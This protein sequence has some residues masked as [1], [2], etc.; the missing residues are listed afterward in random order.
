MT[1]ERSPN[2]VSDDELLRRLSRSVCDS[3]RVEADVV[4]DIGEVDARRLFAREASPSMYSYCTQVLHLSEAEAYL[5]IN[6]ARA[7]RRH[8]ILLT[9]LRDGRLHLT[10]IVKLA[11]HLTEANRDV[12]LARAT[13][14]SKQQVEELLAELF[15]RPDVPVA[16]RKLPQKAAAVEAR[17]SPSAVP[18]ETSLLR[19]D[20]VV[21]APAPPTAPAVVVPLAPARYKVQFTASSELQGKLERLRALM[22][23]KVPDGD[24]AAI[25]EEA[26]TEKLERLEARRFGRATKPRSH[27]ATS[28]TSA[29]SRYIPAAVKRAVSERDDGQCRYRDKEGR[30][31]PETARLEYHHRHPYGYGGDRRPENLALLCHAHNELLAQKDYGRGRP[32]EAPRTG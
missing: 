29:G 18:P 19:L 13:H 15:P 3:R 28:D 9:M 20:A 21:N 10:A 2:V 25:I 5:R 4:A 6:A 8:P 24:L 11:P 32:I 7:A 12:L 22:R 31:C 26:V 30:R 16:I 23:S 14:R 1:E 27:V 17:R